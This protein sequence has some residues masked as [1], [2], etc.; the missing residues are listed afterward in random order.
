MDL[1]QL[2]R[3]FLKNQLAIAGV[4]WPVFVLVH[5]I[6]LELERPGRMTGD[7]LYPL[8]FMVWLSIGV[9]PLVLLGG[10]VHSIALLA[11]PPRVSA[12]TRRIAAVVLAPLVPGTAISTGWVNYLLSFPLP[13]AAAAIVYGLC[14][15]TRVGRKPATAKA[16]SE[17][18][19]VRAVPAL[20]FVVLLLLGLIF[21]KRASRCGAGWLPVNLNLPYDLRAEWSADTFGLEDVEGRGV[22]GAVD[23]L[24]GKGEAEREI[25][26]SVNRYTLEHGFIAEV[27]LW[28]GE[29]AYVALDRPAGS[30]IQKRRLTPEALQQRAGTDVE[31]IRWVDVRLRSC[32]YQAFWPVRVV[33]VVGLAMTLTFALPP[34][35]LA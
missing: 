2:I 20:A 3:G 13:T 7:L 25:M 11:I 23:V 1:R 6:E 8:D 9:L 32:F 35:K 30:A 14:C 4:Y 16:G 19:P 21:E 12:R 22:I 5:L 27:V 24:P 18:A 34:S 17:V 31:S 15:T 26:R 28:S 10:F 33:I 29:L